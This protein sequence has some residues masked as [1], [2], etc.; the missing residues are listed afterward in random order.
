MKLVDKTILLFE[1]LFNVSDMKY[2]NHKIHEIQ[3]SQEYIR[4]SNWAPTAARTQL[5]SDVIDRFEKLEI[6]AL[7]TYSDAL[8]VEQ[9]VKDLDR[10]VS[11]FN[12]I[13]PYLSYQS[14]KT[15]N[16]KKVGNVG[17]E[18][19]AQG[20]KLNEFTTNKLVTKQNRRKV[21][22]MKAFAWYRQAK[23]AFR[24]MIEESK[25][26]LHRVRE[27]VLKFSSL[28]FEYGFAF[29][30]VIAMVGM[31]FLVQHPIIENYKAG[32]M[33]QVWDI[34]I[35]ALFALFVV[36]FIL[37]AAGRAYYKYFAFRLASKLRKQILRQDKSI[38]D[39][40]YLSVKF[41]KDLAKV[42]RKPRKVKISLENVSIMQR[43][44]V[45]PHAEILDFIYCEK[46]FFHD[47]HR[48]V[49]R[50]MNVAFTI[51]TLVFVAVIALFIIL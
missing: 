42:V 41:E 29:L 17:V 39:L 37:L 34:T 46:D 49:L 19:N 2:V 12:G 18:I 7:T 11:E 48:G 4:L 28:D 8:E 47:K 21:V 40:E 5:M 50:M 9:E 43:Y 30:Q 45:M 27:C 38:E 15:Y 44:G 33:E 32:Q 23:Q 13:N 20:M 6:F 22:S 1:T 16:V 31:L 35:T 24:N 51:L 25:S 14:S 3:F 10:R 36:N 26:I